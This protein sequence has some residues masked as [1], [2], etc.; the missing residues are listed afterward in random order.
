MPQY[1]G[2]PGPRSGSGWGGEGEGKG[3]GTFGLAF[4]MQMKKIPN[5]KKNF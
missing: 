4:E 5:F 1:G 3:M 2:T